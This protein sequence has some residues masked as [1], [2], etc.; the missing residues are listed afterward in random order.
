MLGCLKPTTKSRTSD[1]ASCCESFCATAKLFLLLPDPYLLVSLQHSQSNWASDLTSGLG[2]R[3][4][5]GLGLFSV[6]VGLGVCLCALASSRLM[7][8]VADLATL[9]TRMG[10]EPSELYSELS[11]SD[12][13]E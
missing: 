4:F 7:R 9:V 11:T 5:V 1:S 10:W 12:T 2:W 13:A 6:T 3:S 8:R